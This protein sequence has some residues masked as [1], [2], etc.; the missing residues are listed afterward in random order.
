[1]RSNNVSGCRDTVADYRKLKTVRPGWAEFRRV[2]PSLLA[3]GGRVGVEGAFACPTGRV[4]R[5][6]SNR[7]RK[8]HQRSGRRT[9]SWTNDGVLSITSLKGLFRMGGPSSTSLLSFVYLRCLTLRGC[10]VCIPLRNARL[11]QIANLFIIREQKCRGV[12][13]M[14][15]RRPRS[16]FQVHPFE[17]DWASAGGRSER[18]W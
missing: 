3:F 6:K 14:E 7:S 13:K 17:F 1:M 8:V 16:L 18:Q 5:R 10:F 11:F 12:R 2:N 4:R 15:C 9:A